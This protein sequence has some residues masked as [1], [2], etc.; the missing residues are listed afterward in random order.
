VAFSPDGTRLA[1]GSSFRYR[2]GTDWIGG[3]LR[4]WDVKTGKNIPFAG[5]LPPLWQ[6]RLRESAVNFRSLSF[7]P[8]GRILAAA[9]GRFEASGS[10]WSGLIVVWDAQTGK[11]LAALSGHT[12]EVLAVQ[13]SPDGRLLASGGKDALIKLWDVKTW[14]EK[15]TFQGHKTTVPAVAFSPDSKTLASAGGH[16]RNVKLWDVSSG[17]VKATFTGHTDHVSFVAFAPDGRTVASSSGD[18]TIRLWDVKAGE[19]KTTLRGHKDPIRALAFRRDGRH[20]ASAGGIWSGLQ[21]G[22]AG[23]RGEIKLWDVQTGKELPGFT[24]YGEQFSCVAFSADGRRLAAGSM[25]G[26]VQLWDLADLTAK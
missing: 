20:L 7:S 12:D 13:F 23:G 17:Q 1:S 10:K 2:G 6:P 9:I 11:R 19:L 3:D 4:L 8:D 21:P 5:T 26:T 22:G 14:A 25:D 18:R 24:G 16:D 15:A